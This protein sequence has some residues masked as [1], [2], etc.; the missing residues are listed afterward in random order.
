[1]TC[2]AELHN[3][4]VSASTSCIASTV[5]RTMGKQ[6]QRSDVPRISKYCEQCHCYVSKGSWQQHTAGIRH[7]RS[8]LELKYGGPVMSQFECVPQT[9]EDALQEPSHDVRSLVAALVGTGG[10]YH[11]ALKT[12]SRV[13]DLRRGR[14]RVEEAARGKTRVVHRDAQF[15]PANPLD[16]QIA[17]ACVDV[18]A[19]A[20]PEIHVDEGDV[21]QA[22]TVTASEHAKC[23]EC[24]EP[25]PDDSGGA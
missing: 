10:V 21:P 24:K 16:L 9:H 4:T 22:Y 23:G 5:N 3:T 15:M 18:V 13:C 7:R 11:K 2:E 1:M 14:V 25:D 20:D 19:A 12:L 6:K 8:I 17:G